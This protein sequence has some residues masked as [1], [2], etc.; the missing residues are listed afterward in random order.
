MTVTELH[1]VRSVFST[2]AVAPH[3]ATVADQRPEDLAAE[4]MRC[5]E[6]C[7]LAAGLLTRDEPAVAP[8]RITETTA[9]GGPPPPQGPRWSVQ[10]VRANGR[11]AT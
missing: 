10:P 1:P 11:P 5:S 2:E 4:L 3:T 9:A 6:L 8:T 7:R